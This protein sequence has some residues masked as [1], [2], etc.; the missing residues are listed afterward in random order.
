MKL[1][2]LIQCCSSQ[3]TIVP[4]LREYSTI[5]ESKEVVHKFTI[6]FEEYRKLKKSMKMRT[7]LAGLPMAF[8]GMGISSAIHV[9]LNPLM[10]EMTPEEIKPIL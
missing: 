2:P 5:D 7:R 6:S 3:Q 1:I 4:R 8:V 9:T 10:F